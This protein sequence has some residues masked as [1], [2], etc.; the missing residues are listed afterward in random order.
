MH[1]SEKKS[2]N[3]KGIVMKYFS[4]AAFDLKVAIFPL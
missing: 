1:C 3:G 2:K 4:H